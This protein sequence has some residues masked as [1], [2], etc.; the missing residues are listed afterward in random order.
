MVQLATST[1][2]LTVGRALGRGDR[3][4]AERGAALAFR[5]WWTGI[6]AA[7]AMEGLVTLLAAAGTLPVTMLV[8]VRYAGIVLVGAGFW[9]LTYYVSYL[10]M[11]RAGLRVP[12]AV[13]FGVLALA[14]VLLVATHGPRGVDAREWAVL[15]AFETPLRTPL[16]A[17]IV[18]GFVLPPVVACVG[19][20]SLWTKTSHRAQRY[21]IALVSLSVILY[22]VVGLV[23]RLATSDR[24]L[25]AN[26]ALGAPGTALAAWLAYHPPGAVRAWL[27]DPAAAQALRVEERK[28]R[29]EALTAR[30]REML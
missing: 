9:G 3:K 15:I 5:T 1:A 30:C 20:L 22:L 11:G 8:S 29:Q 13:L 19:Y 4:G 16:Y 24:L 12:L 7:L 17:L 6:G 28:A 14:L 2:F 10:W 21:R 23:A 25:F 18:A 26:V 27:E